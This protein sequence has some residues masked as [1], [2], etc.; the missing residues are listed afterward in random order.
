MAEARPSHASNGAATD[1]HATSTDV[2]AMWRGIL[3]GTDPRYRDSH[4]LFSHLPGSPRCFL[5]AAPFKGPG[6]IVAR[7]MG[8]KPWAKNPHYCEACF[9]VLEQGHGGAEIDCT[10]LFADIRGSTTL[11]EGMRPAEFRALLDRFYD[12]AAGVLHEH[13]AIL[14]KF[15]GDEVVA[16]FIPALSGERHASRAV[17][18][19]Q[20]LLGATGHG[21]PDGPWVPVGVGV[22]TGIAFV[23]AV[24]EGPSTT[25]T[26]LG[27]AVNVAAR[28]ASAARAGEV[29]VTTDA[30]RAADIDAEADEAERRDLDL[31]GKSE[32]VSVVVLHA[33]AGAAATA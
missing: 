11:A 17:A 19:A 30:A 20:A 14:D 3:L 8:R 21:Q 4:A 24:G 33:D 9:V 25:I 29:L 27:D 1:D 31:K 18:A 16:I 10:L 6:S 26:A 15:V 32:R 2:D 28:L 13:E 22:H 7:R 23:G 12:A 5:C